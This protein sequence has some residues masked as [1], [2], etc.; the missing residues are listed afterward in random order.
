V[1]TAKREVTTKEQR[2]RPC[3]A[4]SKV[5]P[6]RTKGPLRTK[7]P[8]IYAAEAVGSENGSP[9]QSSWVADTGLGYAG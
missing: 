1:L 9:A 3:S 7:E 4:A 6:L 8:V 2:T 5:T